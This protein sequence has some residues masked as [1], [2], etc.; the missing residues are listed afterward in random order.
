MSKTINAKVWGLLLVVILILSISVVVLVSELQVSSAKPS[1]VYFGVSYGGVS[2]EGAKPLIDKVKGY[3]NVFLIASYDI[4]ANETALNI[5]C[6]YCVQANLKFIVYFQFISRIVYPWHQT[7]MDTAKQ[8]FGSYF[9]GVYLQDEFGGRQIDGN[10]TQKTVLNASSFADAANQF[11]KNIAHFNST[12]DAKRR[13]IPLFIADYALY[14]FDYQAGYDT[15]FAELGS[16]ASVARQ[17]ALC[18]GAADTQGKDWGAIV[19]WKYEQPPYMPDAGEMFSDMVS[20]YSAGAKYVLVFNYPTYPSGNPYGVLSEEDFSALQQFWHYVN[21]YPR[22]S[23]GVQTAQAALVLP[24]DYG[25]AMRRSNYITSDSI[26]GLF[27]EDSKAS[28][29]LNST[30]TLIDRYGLK[31]DIVYDDIRYNVTNRYGQVYYWNST[32]T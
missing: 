31:L 11:V 2:A 10:A 20:A 24:A 13:D 5:I 29:V 3:T 16:N 18:R 9:L 14:W 8:Q 23:Y 12:Q 21:T 25:W 28:M 27:P 17:I 7:W 4:T 32:L 1:D 6:N 26:W 19:A 22:E 30:N 15:V